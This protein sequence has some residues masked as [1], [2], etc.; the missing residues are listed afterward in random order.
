MKDTYYVRQS[1]P[2][3]EPFVRMSTPDKVKAVLSAAGSAF[4][5]PGFTY[6]VYNGDTE[7]ARFCIEEEN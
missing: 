4:V 2:G 6:T 5:N 7:I 3:K 1:A